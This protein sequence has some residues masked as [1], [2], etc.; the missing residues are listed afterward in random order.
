MIWWAT[1]NQQCIDHTATFV[2]I[3]DPA[4]LLKIAACKNFIATLVNATD[5]AKNFGR[6]VAAYK[7]LWLDSALG[8]VA[9]VNPVAPPAIVPPANVVVGLKAYAQLL[10]G[11]LNA[12]PSMTDNIRTAMGISGSA[13]G[14]GT[15]R[16]VSVT[17][18]AGSGVA[19]R[20]GMAGHPA[21]A[22]YR[23]RNNVTERLG[24][25]TMADFPDMA[26]P[27]VAGLSESR[28]YWIAGIVNNVES[29]TISAVVRV[30]TTP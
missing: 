3:L 18:L 17:A 13:Q 20:L 5:D 23:K 1:F 8:S 27:L 15:V 30:A 10:A 12:H 26:P 25:S 2:S 11:Q 4:T 22:V 16:I 24:V 7:N 21:V 6:D 19:L 14:L 9:P 28:E 29:G